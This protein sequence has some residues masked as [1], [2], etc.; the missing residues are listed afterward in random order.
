MH[1]V[2]KTRGD[3]LKALA[4]TAPLRYAIR[5]GGRSPSMGELHG[6]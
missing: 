5:L 6:R 4:P 3:Y 2:Q 1:K